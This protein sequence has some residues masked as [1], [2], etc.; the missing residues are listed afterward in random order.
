MANLKLA[1]FS[2]GA[3]QEEAILLFKNELI[4][5]IKTENKH[6]IEFSRLCHTIVTISIVGSCCYNYFIINM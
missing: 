5:F 4:I 3:H 6:W 2:R 1:S